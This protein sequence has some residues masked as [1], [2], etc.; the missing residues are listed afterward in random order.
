LQ[1]RHTGSE[2]RNLNGARL[3]AAAAAGRAIWLRQNSHNI[4]L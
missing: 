1:Y 4:M 3:H 2:R